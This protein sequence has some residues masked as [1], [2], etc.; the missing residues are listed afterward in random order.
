VRTA[1]D[2]TPE[3]LRGGFYT[4]PDLVGFCLRRAVENAPS[5][6]GLRLLEPSIGDG[7]FV[8]GLQGTNLRHRIGH[9]LGLE[10]LD[11]EAEK[12][13]QS[14]RSMAMSGEVLTA[15][16]IQWAVDETHRDFDLA[17]G[18]PPFVRFQFVERRDRTAADQLASKLGVSFRGV[19]NLWIP[20]LLA[21]ISQ[22]R[23]GGGLAFVV[24]TECFTGCAAQV[25][26]DWL[27]RNVRDLHFDLFPPGS[28]P[29]VLQEITVMSGSRVDSKRT[30][31]M[32]VKITE[33]SPA[34]TSHSWRNDASEGESWTRYLLRPRHLDALEE[35]R[36]L[37]AI[38]DLGDVA[39]FEVSIVTGANTFFTVDQSTLDQY[40][41]ERWARPLVP[42]IRHV[43]GLIYEKHDQEN[44]D[45]AG[46]RAWL[47]DFNSDGD[48]PAQF[49]NAAR[50]LRL[51]EAQMLH[52][53]YKCRIRS[54]WY[55]VPGIRRG[56]L[57]LS[58]R[59]H[60]FPRV[61]LNKAGVFTTDTIY[62][63]RMRDRSAIVGAASLAATFHNSLT[64]LTAEI[65]G[66]SFGGGVLELVPS[67]VGR[68]SVP[69]V[70]G[71]EGWLPDLDA[72]MRS[73]S[74]EDLIIETDSRLSRSRAIPK[75]LLATLAEARLHMLA[76]RLDRNT[77][78]TAALGGLGWRKAA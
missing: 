20:L 76:R 7:A 48:D 73:G 13:R 55:R 31:P 26:R 22:L 51:G 1:S 30:S 8:R 61:A 78:D 15:S 10:V 19:S 32:K 39:A 36:A 24:P 77:S 4:P 75:R 45:A 35:A 57:L 9:V 68:L 40:G 52:E 49:S 23:T 59:S 60:T 37:P 3:K 27:L 17:V 71:A 43:E 53:R 2:V 58:K 50:Y 65:E 12:A 54:P 14:L 38:R 69:L 11:I 42:R 29:G 64:L 21:S 56:E 18:N 67:E 5:G 70:S 41:L 62:R 25:A 44:T 16:T 74:G 47:L 33:H 66:R 46:G 28:F 72:T 34:G 6:G 63:G